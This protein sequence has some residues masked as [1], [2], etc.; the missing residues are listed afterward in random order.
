MAD[1][2]SLD[3]LMDE[4]AASTP[5]ETTSEETD[6]PTE[7]AE[8]TQI[9]EVEEKK[10]S[11]KKTEEKAPAQ[12]F[13]HG[14]KYREAAAQ[15]DKN[16][17]YSVDE[18]LELVKKTSYTKFDGSVEVHVNLTPAKK[19]D[20]AVRGTV[21]LPH[22]TGRERR[23]VII[24]DEMIEKIEK[25]WMDFDVAVATPDMMPKLAKLAKVLGPKGLMPNP[26]SGTVTADPAK[27]AEELKGGRVEFKA[28]SLGNIHQ[29]I[30]K[31]SWDVAK[32]AENLQTFAGA[33]PKGR[34]RT[35]SLA[36]TMGPGVKVQL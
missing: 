11:K 22:G 33:L 19:N 14:A 25:G 10:S 15:I 28:D 30:G 9:E 34:V 20:E 1:E 13:S 31:V 24:T 4:V 16:K 7:T 6:A 35:I 21:T 17:V 8:E 26:K 36:P 29:A 3:Q 2:N 32:L 12:K 23:V 18:A 5:E 27:A